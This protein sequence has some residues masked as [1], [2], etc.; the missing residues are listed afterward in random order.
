MQ[1]KIEVQDTPHANKVINQCAQSSKVKIISTEPGV[2]GHT[3]KIIEA[4]EPID[5]FKFGGMMM[6]YYYLPGS[7]QEAQQMIESFA[8]SL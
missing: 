7:E 2:V 4:S 3:V 6:L 5:L 8:E 1:I